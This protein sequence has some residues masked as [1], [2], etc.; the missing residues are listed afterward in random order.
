MHRILIIGEDIIDRD[1]SFLSVFGRLSKYKFIKNIRLKNKSDVSLII[2]D[3]KQHR[4]ESF[5]AFTKA[6][7]DVPK[8]VISSDN[9]ISGLTPWLRFPLTFPLYS[10]H[11]KE[12]VFIAQHLMS[13]RKLQ[14]ENKEFKTEL[15]YAKKEMDFFDE[16]G[17][18]LISDNEPEELFVSVMEK[19]KDFI[20][21]TSWS[22][23]LIDE[24]T[25]DL[26]LDKTDD[27]RKK[28]KLS[29]PR[30]K[31]GEGI[32]G[33]V[34]KEGIP[35]IVPDASKDGKPVFDNGKHNKEQKEH[36]LMCVPVRSKGNV[37]GVIEFSKKP[38]EGQFTRE[39]LNLLTK[40]MDFIALTI[41]KV[42]LNRKITEL[43]LTDDLTKLFNMRHL[44]RAIEV[45]INRCERYKKSV[46]LIFMDVDDFK[47]IND[48]HGHLVG[49][50]V[51]TELGQ[52]LLQYL[53]SIDIVGRYGG[54]EFVI[55]LPHTT[56]EI[57]LKVAERIRKA[58]GTHSFLKKDRLNIR[59][60][61]SFGIASY[62]ESA[63]TKEQLLKLADDAMYKVKHHAKNGVHMIT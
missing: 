7:F 35:V 23:H 29:K 3:K 2:V 41:E 19:T 8:L 11:E 47:Q 36:S 43:T 30:L 60:T 5:M 27:A 4:E 48:R 12:L 53:R 42:S 21:G 28:R 44:N 49:S 61:G 57:A 33:W 15:L 46:S 10:I 59:I 32:L 25:G 56:P 16:V 20:R 14:L 37:I 13:E 58:I 38:A 22:A 17:K 6:F 26:V 51:L 54:D 1:F 45:E 63:K 55:V 50:R 62:P 34:A 24:E 52:F 18:M 31:S 9:S 40:V 39:D